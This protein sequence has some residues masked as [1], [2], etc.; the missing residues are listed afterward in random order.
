MGRSKEKGVDLS[1]PQVVKLDD[2][3][4]LLLERGE[5]MQQLEGNA[6][7]SEKDR[8]LLESRVARIDGQLMQGGGTPAAV[9]AAARAAAAKRKA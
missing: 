1:D 6:A 5:L 4:E 8:L 2:S 7:L 9:V 3:E